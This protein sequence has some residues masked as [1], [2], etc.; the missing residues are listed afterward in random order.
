MV[1]SWTYTDCEG[2]FQVYTHT[3][4]IEYEDFTMP[5]DGSSTVTCVESAVAPTLPTVTDNCGNP[6]TPTGPTMSGTLLPGGCDGTVIY[7]YNYA[8]CEGNTHDW[9]YT[10]N[11]TKRPT[12]LTFDIENVYTVQYSDKVTL[13]AT[14][15]DNCK[16]GDDALIN[17]RS[18]I[19]SIGT[20]SQ[21]VTTVNGVASFEFTITQ[22][23]GTVLA[24]ASFAAVCPYDAA[25]TIQHGFSII[26]ENANVDYIGTEVQATPTSNG[27]SAVVEL[28][29]IVQ[30]ISDGSS[31]DIRNACVSF[32]VDGT[33]VVS[34]LVPALIDPDDIST[35]VVSFNYTAVIG[36]APYKDFT[37][38][39]VVD[40]YYTGN[41]DAVLTVYK[42]TGDF[43]TGGGHII[44]TQSGG[45]YASTPGLK[46]NFGFHVKFN[47]KGTNLQGGMNII[48]RRM[49]DGVKRDYQIKT[50][51]MTSLG[52][53]VSTPA[54]KTAEFTSKANLKDVT[55]PLNPINLGGNLTLRVTMVD[56][57]EPG[58]NDQIGITLWDGTTLL[59][60]SWWTGSNTEEM[61]LSG[62]NLVVHSGFNV[63]SGKNEEF[64]II[65][66]DV[67]PAAMLEVYPNP[68]R[69]KAT[70]RFVP[71]ADSKA[72]LEIYHLNGSLVQT[73]YEG[74][75]TAGTLYEFVY[76]PADRHPGM[77][78][79]RLVLDNKVIN[80]KLVIQQ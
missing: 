43:I 24:Q 35:G 63:T 65:P 67:A 64:E 57:G 45:Q 32:I 19:L 48:F 60:S 26:Q 37:I 71:Q 76:Q 55:N 79:Y 62:G 77:L 13:T 75:V 80:G 2:N 10:Y 4:T 54:A 47:K 3:V 18:V 1:Y 68:T 53:N 38:E 44:P 33:N 17:G 22:E 70:F 36:T 27:T 11:V 15:T 23:P 58:S 61:L 69:D 20:Q 52:V 56:R 42:P 6:L 39:V 31:G 51:A 16:T 8:D 28:R 29:A 12:T 78:L 9:V 40:C 5:S 73:L 25:A 34:G 49:V 50:N 14:L 41:D 7:T 66:V 72:R 30:D 59:Y 46:T 21:S 74:D